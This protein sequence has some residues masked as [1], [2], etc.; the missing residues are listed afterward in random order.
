MTLALHCGK[1]CLSRTLSL[2]QRI[3]IGIND[4]T[5]INLIHL[6]F[7]KDETCKEMKRMSPHVIAKYLALLSKKN[8]VFYFTYVDFGNKRM[9][10]ILIEVILI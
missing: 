10:I 3:I 2:C 6:R 7:S 8:S 9:F 5:R 4:N 1:I